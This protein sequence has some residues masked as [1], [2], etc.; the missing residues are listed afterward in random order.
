MAT[1]TVTPVTSAGVV[2]TLVA[3]SAGGD[4]Y[5][6]SN[7][8]YIEINNASGGSIT[9]YAAI[10]ADGQTIVQGR[11][12]SV[13]AGVRLKIAPRGSTYN[14]PSTNRV[15]L[16]YSAVTSVTVGVFY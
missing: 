1:L 6:N 7:S 2:A 9:L 15:S 16:T 14:D 11:S 8:P 12:W 4:V 13:G 10:Y 5:D 3:A